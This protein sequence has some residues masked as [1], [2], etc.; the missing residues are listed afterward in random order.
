MLI[1]LAIWLLIGACFAWGRARAQ[2][3]QEFLDCSRRGLRGYNL[4]RREARE[5]AFFEFI[6]WTLLG[7]LSGV[8]YIAWV[9]ATIAASHEKGVRKTGAINAL[10]F[11]LVVFGLS[12]IAFGNRTSEWRQLERRIGRDHAKAHVKQRAGSPINPDEP[13]DEEEHR[14]EEE[15]RRYEEIMGRLPR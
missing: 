8:S 1:V 7:T 15:V 9:L 14:W 12:A 10:I 4:V 5:A 13:R 2:Y 3:Y 11:S 6:K